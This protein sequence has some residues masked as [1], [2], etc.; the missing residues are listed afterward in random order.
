M[1]IR[2]VIKEEIDDFGWMDDIPHGT[3]VGEIKGLPG[4]FRDYFNL[5]DRILID[6]GKVVDDGKTI[7]LSGETFLVIKVL[8][9]RVSIRPISQTLIATFIN[10]FREHYIYLG[11]ESDD[12]HILLHKV[13]RESRI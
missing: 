13:E 2:K 11:V 3:S 5:G 4:G 7:D 9:T 12:D 6:D 10:Q 1:D 8:R